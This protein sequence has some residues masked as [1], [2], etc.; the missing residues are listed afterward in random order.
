MVVDVRD[1]LV[2]PPLGVLGTILVGVHEPRVVVFVLVVMG[3]MRELAHWTAGVLV[4]HVPVVMGVHLRFMPVLVSLVPDDLLLGLDGH[5]LSSIAMS[6]GEQ[7][8]R[9]CAVVAE[10]VRQR[11]ADRSVGQRGRR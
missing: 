3:L 11:A 10:V 4:S 8:Q 7:Q 2:V 6:F 1:G 5:D 9:A